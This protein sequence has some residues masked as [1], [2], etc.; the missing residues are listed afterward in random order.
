MDVMDTEVIFEFITQGIS[1]RVTAIHVASGKEVV[2]IAPQRSPRIYQ[3]QIALAK[4]KRA[5]GER[6]SR[7]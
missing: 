5:M 4:L 3:Q 6:L 1:V 7:G 2:I